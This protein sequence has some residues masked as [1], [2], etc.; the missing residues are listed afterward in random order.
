MVDAIKQNADK[1]Q[2][3]STAYSTS[4]AISQ[5]QDVKRQ[6]CTSRCTNKVNEDSYQVGLSS[7][8]VFYYI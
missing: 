1:D 3:N 2:E 5:D 7:E 8:S 4:P 6:C